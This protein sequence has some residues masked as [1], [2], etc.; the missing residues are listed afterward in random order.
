[1]IVTDK[2]NQPTGSPLIVHNIG[3]GPRLEDILFRYPITGH[4]RYSSK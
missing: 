2:F 1:G 3:K 4:Y